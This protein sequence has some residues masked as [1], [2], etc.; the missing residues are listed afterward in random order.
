MIKFKEY[1]LQEAPIGDFQKVGDWQ[2]DA[3]PRKY[4]KASIG[5]LN[6]EVGVKKIHHAFRNT[7]FLFD[8]YFFRTSQSTKFTEVGKVN[9]EWVKNN[10]KYDLKTNDDAITVIFTNNTAAEKVP[11]TSW[12]IA[13]RIGHTSRRGDKGVEYEW[14]YL[15]KELKSYC[16]NFMEHHYGIVPKVQYGLGDNKHPYGYIAHILGTMKSARDNNISRPNEFL[17]ELFAQYIINGKITLN[18]NL[19]KFVKVN[20]PSG[21]YGHSSNYWRLQREPDEILIQEMEQML[22]SCFERI[23]GRMINSVFVM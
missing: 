3:K 6:S 17:Y 13:H 14:E 11:L 1:F 18:K 7:Q 22:D 8:L 21:G 19:P 12:T 16:N 15:I 9:V 10:L 2:P 23:L 20:L 4:D 5:I